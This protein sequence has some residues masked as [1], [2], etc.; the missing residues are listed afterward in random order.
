MIYRIVCAW[1][2]KDMGVKDCPGSKEMK[3]PISHSICQAC[4]A[5]V[6]AEIEQLKKGGAGCAMIS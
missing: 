4:K 6:K 3:D 5:K 2:G 1:C